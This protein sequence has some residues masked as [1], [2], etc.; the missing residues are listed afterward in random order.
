MPTQAE[1]KNMFDYGYDSGDVLSPES[2]KRRLIEE[3]FIGGSYRSVFV[4]GILPYIKSNSAV[5]ELG[6]GRG[7]WSKAILRFITEGK[8]HVV[9]FQNVAPWL[10]PEKYNGRLVCHQVFDNS[11]SALE[12]EHFDFFW[13]FG[14]LCHNNVDDIREVLRNSLSKMKKWGIAVHQYSNWEKLERFGWER[15]G[16]PLEFRNM[17]DGQIWW[18]RNDCKTMARIAEEAGWKV[19][20]P[21]LGLIQRDSIMVMQ[22]S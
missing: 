17:P 12:N 9:D 19:L 8:L 20:N 2:S 15:G 7:S 21:D 4:N 3:F 10:E 5:L 22:R 14:V 18:P 6:P 13:S 16:V 11:F 1:L